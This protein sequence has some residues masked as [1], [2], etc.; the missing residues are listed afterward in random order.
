MI[1]P[2]RPSVFKCIF[3]PFRP[4]RPV[5][6]SYTTWVPGYLGSPVVPREC[7]VESG[8][9]SRGGSIKREYSLVEIMNDCIAA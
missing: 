1:L 9:L 6:C 4:L 3:R 8:L 2:S 7:T 5:I